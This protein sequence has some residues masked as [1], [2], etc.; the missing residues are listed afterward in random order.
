MRPIVIVAVFMVGIFFP[1]AAS[2]QRCEWF[3]GRP[4]CDPGCT[5]LRRWRDQDGGQWFTHTCVPPLP[6]VDDLAL[7]L[8]IHPLFVVAAGIGALAG[9]VVIIVVTSGA[10]SV[11]HENAISEPETETAQTIKGKLDAAA[12]EADRYIAEQ[13][14]QAY[15]R[16][17]RSAKDHRYD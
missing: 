17:R 6:I 8:G 4:Y 1:S 16:G 15:E 5:I 13:I 9:I 12:D 11:R 3:K 14:A 7:M 2:A 10:A